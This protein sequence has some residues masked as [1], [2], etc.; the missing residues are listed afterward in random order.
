MRSIYGQKFPPSNFFRIGKLCFYQSALLV[1]YIN[2]IKYQAV[3]A[4]CSGKYNEA[5]LALNNLLNDISFRNF[6]HAELEIKLF[7]ALC[8]LLNNKAELADSLIKNVQR[9]LRDAESET[10]PDAQ[11]F[12]KML[13]VAMDPSDKKGVEKCRKLLEKFQSA[14]AGN[15]K[16]L[17][18]LRIDDALL[19]SISRAM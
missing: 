8:Y 7:L 14:N 5:V 3:S 16:M 18:Y 2:Y 6:F 10:F 15:T 1:N 13:S 11:S 19:K 17:D 9:K 4:F 12:A